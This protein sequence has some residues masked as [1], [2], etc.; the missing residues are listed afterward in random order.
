MRDDQINSCKTLDTL[1]D[2]DTTLIIAIE[3]CS[4][5]AKVCTK[6]LRT[7][8]DKTIRNPPSEA[9]LIE[10]ITDVLICI[11]RLKN[12]FSIMDG[13]II[14]MADCKIRRFLDLYNK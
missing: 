2:K 7:G 12:R 3:E 4:E 6:M 8:K 14:T 1:Q 10:E 9:D 5:L 13:D 11:E